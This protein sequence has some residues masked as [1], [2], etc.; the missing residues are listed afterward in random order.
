M[1]SHDH[2]CCIHLFCLLIDQF[3]QVISLSACH[4][5]MHLHA[6]TCLVSVAE[7]KEKTT[8]F[9]INSMRSEVLHWAAQLNVAWSVRLQCAAA[10]TT[11]N[12]VQAA[13][14][15]REGHLTS[16]LGLLQMT[17]ESPPDHSDRIID[18][19]VTPETCNKKGADQC[20]SVNT[21]RQVCRL[22]LHHL[23]NALSCI[24]CDLPP[25]ALHCHLAAHTCQAKHVSC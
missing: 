25:L 2:T 5:N 19:S 23:S 1:T 14:Q 20:C 9:G 3:G 7:R 22:H 12:A 4:S 17:G 24:E 15:C 13:R 8:P 10:A 16:Y 11:C 18:L 6:H 21:C